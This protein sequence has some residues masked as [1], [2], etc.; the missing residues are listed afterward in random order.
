MNSRGAVLSF[1]KSGIVPRN[2]K[3]PSEAGVPCGEGLLI[4][5]IIRLI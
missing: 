1:S 3:Y 4:G 5:D 2:R